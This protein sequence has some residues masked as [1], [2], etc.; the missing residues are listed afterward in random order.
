MK[1]SF[2]NSPVSF[3][4]KQLDIINNKLPCRTVEELEQL[5]FS[6][7]T[8][9]KQEESLVSMNPY[10]KIFVE[11]IFQRLFMNSIGGTTG[12]DFTQRVFKKVLTNELAEMCSW[13][14]AKNNYELQ[15]LSIVECAYGE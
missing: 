13:T 5:E 10:L 11:V 14:G 1:E 15:K 3:S 2:R 12:R 8:D 9:K 6:I 7:L 4:K